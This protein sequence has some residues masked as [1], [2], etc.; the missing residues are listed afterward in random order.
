VRS[1]I[2]SFS[3]ATCLWLALW[4]ALPFGP[5]EA[6]PALSHVIAS[7]FRFVA[8]GQLRTDL[9]ASLIRVSAGVGIAAFLVLL[10]S[11][12]L[13]LLPRMSR[14]VLLPLD[15]LRSIPPI[16]LAPLLIGLLGVGSLPAVAVVAFGA[17]FPMYQAAR[18]GL[19]SVG[20]EHL[21]VARVFGASRVVEV[22]HIVLPSALPAALSGLKSA[23]SL[24]WFC[25]IAAEMLGAS[26]GLGF[27]LQNLTLNLNTGAAWFYIAVIAVAGRVMLWAADFASEQICAWSITR[28]EN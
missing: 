17:F 3:V 20:Q 5:D 7:G 21:D 16:A 11:L 8:N 26:S 14:A 12:L 10:C 27:R 6:L 18:F 9:V 1:R 4:A 19:E 25:V 13:V 28:K 22:V 24:G 2:A 15:F 23:L